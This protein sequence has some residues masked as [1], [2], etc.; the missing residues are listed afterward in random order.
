MPSPVRYTAG[1]STAAKGTVLANYPQEDP[2]KVFTYFNDFS[3]YLASEWTVTTVGTTPTA[4]ITDGAFG[5][6]L[7]TT[8]GAD[9]DGIQLQKVGEAF[10]PVAG[11]KMWFKTKFQISDATQ[12]DFLFGIAV[13]DTTA[14]AASGDGVTDGIF[15][16]KDD[17]S[18]SVTLYCQKDATTGQTSAASVATMVAATD[19]ELGFEYDGGTN[20]RYFVDGVHKGTLELSTAAGFLPDTE[21]RVTIAFL[22]GAAAIITANVDYIFAA[23]ER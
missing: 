14:I 8:T 9:N 6:L 5:R 18:T 23:I 22:T 20:I 19:I 1:V 21:C 12:S 16:Q 2:T 10:L 15:F 7:L 13:T 11:K 4:A 3:D 17:A